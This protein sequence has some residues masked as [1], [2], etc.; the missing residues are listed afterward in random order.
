MQGRLPLRH[1]RNEGR[2]RNAARRRKVAAHCGVGD[3]DADTSEAGRR[4]CGLCPDVLLGCESWA[5]SR[6]MKGVGVVALAETQVGEGLRLQFVV[7]GLV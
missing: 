3:G 5:A 4:R 6:Q 1:S 7:C 2:I